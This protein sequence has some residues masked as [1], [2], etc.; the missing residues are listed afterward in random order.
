MKDSGSGVSDSS[1][2]RKTVSLVL[3]SGGA[4]GMAHVGVI[5]YLLDQD[6]DIRCISG[7][8]I[9][10]LVGGIYATGRL[11]LF[12]DWLLALSKTDVLRYLDFSFS[13]TALFRGEKVI[14]ALR[15]LVGEHLIEDLPVTYTAVATDVE[16]QKEVWLSDGPLFDAIRAS[17]A[18][19]TIFTP[20]HYR[21]MRLLDGGLLNP[22]PIAPTLKEV[23]DL[24][25]AVNLNAVSVNHSTHKPSHKPP[26]NVAGR[27]DMTMPPTGIVEVY[28][29]RISGF[30][31]ELQQSFSDLAFR[32]SAAD[33]LGLFD[34][35]NNSFETMQ[36]AITNIKL[37][38]YSPDVV[39]E[40]PRETCKAHEFY[41]A[42][43]LVEVG[44]ERAS[45]AIPSSI[46]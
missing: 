26:H 2:A 19:P 45:E 18:V 39:I 7:A 11:D 43:E 35:L 28:H 20:Y 44:Y 29:R 21:G 40:I 31:D 3:G 1:V 37:A 13:G 16:R 33:D 34:L 46:T 38:T 17:I 5:E 36:N 15:E 32:S 9:G 41:R 14:D 10:A 23:T 6:Y 27:K 4:R 42:R 24:T 25:I 22:V 30:L 12:R 8:S